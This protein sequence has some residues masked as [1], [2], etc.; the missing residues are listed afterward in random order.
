[1]RITHSTIAFVLCASLSLPAIAAP[2]A[3][4]APPKTAAPAASSSA[5]AA[6]SS[7]P[8]KKKT[9][10]V[11]PLAA[12]GLDDGTRSLIQTELRVALTKRG[13]KLQDATATQA[14]VTASRLSCVESDTGCLVK[15][16][17]IATVEEIV[18]GRI[19]PAPGG[20]KIVLHLVDVEGARQVKRVEDLLAADPAGRTTDIARVVGELLGADPVGGDIRI[21]C[22]KPNAVVLIDGVKV[23]L[24]PLAAPVKGLVRGRHTIEVRLAGHKS[25]QGFAD[26]ENGKTADITVVMPSMVDEDEEVVISTGPLETTEVREGG[27][28][29]QPDDV[30]LIPMV[31][32]VA[33]TGSVI[34]GVVGL[35]LGVGGLGYAMYLDQA[36]QQAPVQSNALAVQQS[37]AFYVG[38]G[39]LVATA[40][41]V[42]LGG[43]LL[44]SSF[45]VE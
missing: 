1:M 11:L 31:L 26:V 2:Q 44:A 21:T 8:V 20:H 35:V 36:I 22:D 16:G 3:T 33:G 41:G 14:H 24:T 45:F 15:L 6:P 5:P 43:A 34:V 10:A 12:V 7:A 30:S 39:G 42:L 28:P 9:T 13:A 32:L 18:A 4:P 19:E 25:F 17:F 40:V 23:G 38:V 37:G 29:E 27:A